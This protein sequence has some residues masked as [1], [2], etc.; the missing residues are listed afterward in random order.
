MSIKN[1]SKG[2][3]ENS[4]KYI[5]EQG[6]VTPKS[7]FENLKEKMNVCNVKVAF[8]GISDCIFLSLVISIILWLLFIE[9]DTKFIRSGVYLLS[10]IIYIIT[11]SLV[12]LKEMTLNL[13]E[14]KMVCRYNLQLL[15]TFRMLYFS[16]INLI[17][18]SVMLFFMQGIGMKNVIFWKLLGISF[19]STFIYG[20]LMILFRLKTG[21]I[22]S[23]WICSAVWILVNLALIRICGDGFE[24]FFMNLQGYIIVITLCISCF[25]YLIMLLVNASKRIEGEKEYAIN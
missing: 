20:I 22:I 15:T 14:M 23:Q 11:Y 9:I 6:V 25:G 16:I 8:S 18:N 2:K 19:S 17:L 24:N 4:I 12:V 1:L 10:P 7:H 5:V 21:T 13:Y 3:N